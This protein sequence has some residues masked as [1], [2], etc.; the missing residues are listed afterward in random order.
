MSQPPGFLDP[1]HP[2]YVCRLHKALYGLNQAPRAWYTCF[3]TILCSQ[4]FRG[5]AC[6]TSSLFIRHTSAGSIHLLLYVDDMILTGSDQQGI[7]ALLSFLH[8]HENMKD[9]GPL[10]Y[11]LGME[12]YRQ[13]RTVILRQQKDAL[14]LL[15]RADM[16]DSRPFATPLTSGTEL[17]KLDGT[18]FS[19]PTYFILLFKYEEK[20]FHA[21]WSEFYKYKII[22]FRASS[23]ASFRSL[24]LISVSFSS[25]V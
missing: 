24:A 14:D 12:V 25:R 10:H 5:S 15:R 2:G 22:H 6:D 9:L 23:L 16:L 18:A 17:P 4:G 20:D 8:A 7:L 21:L 13:G 3:S 19:D 1:A 11:F